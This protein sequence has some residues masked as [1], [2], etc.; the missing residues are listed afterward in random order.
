MLKKILSLLPKVEATKQQLNQNNF[1]NYI[2]N[3]N[4][5]A[6]EIKS[7]FHF[8]IPNYIIDEII[9]NEK[10]K[11]YFNLHCLVNCAVLN[12]KLSEKN[13]K[14]IKEKYS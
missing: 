14:I 9:E 13:G 10:N 1:Q 11:N 5:K 12:G 3:W 2:E 7:K 4:K 8:S 6:C